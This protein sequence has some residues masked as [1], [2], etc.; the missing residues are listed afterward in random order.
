MA[1]RKQVTVSPS[2]VKYIFV[3][4]IFLTVAIFV[5]QG[6]RKFFRSSSYFRIRTIAVEDPNL[7]FIAKEDLARYRGRSI[8]DV[9]VR[10]LQRVLASKYPQVSSLKIIKNFP[11]QISVVAK[12]RFPTFQLI[13]RNKL[14]ILDSNA[15]VM[16]IS[17]GLDPNLTVLTGVK[18]GVSY[19]GPGTMI[20][21]DRV[22]SAL[23]V[24]RLF[25]TTPGLSAIKILKINAASPSGLEIYLTDEFKVIV[26]KDSF[27]DK[28]NV[29]S[30]M[31]SQGRLNIAQI[32]YI[33]L[34]FNEPILGKR[35]Q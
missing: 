30:M 18:L 12:K 29:L 23:K 5:Y 24:F 27:G 35:E 17:G 32:S 15:V 25:K 3:L 9:N 4:L 6:I 14:V 16:G 13:H 8:F 33:D 20:R 31:L 10:D 22:I 19:L 28:A 34:R 1:K 7:Q 21:D 11:D 2:A 26:D